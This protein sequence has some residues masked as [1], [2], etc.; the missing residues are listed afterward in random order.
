M[1]VST[2]EFQRF[3]HLYAVTDRPYFEPFCGQMRKESRKNAGT[4]L[5]LLFHVPCNTSYKREQREAHQSRRRNRTMYA[6]GLARQCLLICSASAYSFCVAKPVRTTIEVYSVRAP[7][8]FQRQT[9]APIPSHLQNRTAGDESAEAWTGHL[10]HSRYDGTSIVS[11]GGG[12]DASKGATLHSQEEAKITEV[13]SEV[14][15]LPALAQ[16]DGPGPAVTA[17]AKGDE[18]A[19]P[20]QVLG[21]EHVIDLQTHAFC[22]FSVFLL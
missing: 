11:S 4:S 5:S 21:G 17:P 16:N 10:K 8:H 22:V 13:G 1:L 14:G 19:N 9:P 2:D 7:D 3:S 12:G 20:L 18:T 6:P 15:H